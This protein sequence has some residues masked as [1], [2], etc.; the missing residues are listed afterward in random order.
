MSGFKNKSDLNVEAA[1]L[2]HEKNYYPAVAHTAYYA[3]V[4]LMLH[5]ST[6]KGIDLAVYSKEATGGKSSHVELINQIIV[7][8][9]PSKKN[10][11][12][13]RDIQALKKLRVDADYR[14]VT[15]GYDQ[16]KKA[17]EKTQSVQAILK[18]YL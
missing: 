9:Q 8:L 4:Q 11:D 1:K 16:S 5:Y 18:Q 7:L 2:L 6:K 14:D 12:F 13:N 10:V 3:C 17:L 15:I